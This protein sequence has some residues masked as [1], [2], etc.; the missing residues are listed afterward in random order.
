MLD[1]ESGHPACASQLTKP[2]PGSLEAAKS[3]P[4]Y[5]SGAI[6]GTLTL[7]AGSPMSTTAAQPMPKSQLGLDP[8]EAVEVSHTTVR[9]R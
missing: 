1:V 5:Y 9:E 7:S 3:Q 6:K 8:L 2:G 4:Q